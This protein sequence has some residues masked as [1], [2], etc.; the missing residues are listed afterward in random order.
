MNRL[1]VVR[2]HLQDARAEQQRILRMRN[3]L[4][5]EAWR[6]ETDWYRS[7]Y[8]VVHCRLRSQERT[9]VSPYG[10]GSFTAYHA[11]DATIRQGVWR[12]MLAAS[13]TDPSLVPT[14][15]NRRHVHSR[16]LAIGSADLANRLRQSLVTETDFAVDD[17]RLRW[18]NEMLNRA[19]QDVR[20]AEQA[21]EVLWAPVME[22][23][24]ASKHRRSLQKRLFE[25]GVLDVAPG[26]ATLELETRLAAAEH[27]RERLTCVERMSQMG[28]DSESLPVGLDPIDLWQG[29]Y[30]CT[31]PCEL[32]PSERIKSLRNRN[33][34]A[35]AWIMEKFSN[36]INAYPCKSTPGR[37]VIVL[38][39][40]AASSP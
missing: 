20:E 28:I 9:F 11:V 1:L 33:K 19:D 32:S 31:V 36:R 8:C 7:G 16:L 39:G 26:A 2:K 24:N 21:V 13:S 18:F 38:K 23:R 17:N 6:S 5:S 40:L 25:L 3:K 35:A 10:Q 12:K 30:I 22:K 15:P 27:E 4:L 14:L 34:V 37:E 29:G